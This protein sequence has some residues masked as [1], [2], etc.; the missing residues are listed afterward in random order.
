MDYRSRTKLTDLAKIS[1]PNYLKLP[2][3]SQLAL[4]EQE[5]LRIIFI[6]GLNIRY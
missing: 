3:N 5:T 2:T 6:L 4:N 1:K